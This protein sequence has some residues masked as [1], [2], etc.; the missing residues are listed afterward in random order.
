MGFP[1]TRSDQVDTRIR[2]YRE[3]IEFYSELNIKRAQGIEPNCA[4]PKNAETFR[5]D[6]TKNAR[7][8]KAKICGSC[9]LKT[10]CLRDGVFEILH[11]GYVPKV[12]DVGFSRA[13]LDPVVLVEI[14]TKIY[15]EG[16]NTYEVDDARREL[17]RRGLGVVSS[18]QYSQAS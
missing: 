8:E 2:E 16:V 3:P 15:D 11:T 6:N 13:G 1:N 7:I 18:E 9:L 5:L 4:T 14:A 10:E 17:D 12:R